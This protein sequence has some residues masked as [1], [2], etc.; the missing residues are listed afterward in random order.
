MA[1]VPNEPAAAP[2]TLS[3]HLDDRTDL[4]QTLLGGLHT[5]ST[6][7]TVRMAHGVIR[8]MQ[9]DKLVEQRL[10]SSSARPTPPTRAAGYSGVRTP[11]T[12]RW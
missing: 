10:R 8:V 2:S 4:R 12:G 1:R 7:A 9:T 11:T 6:P 3:L 5:L